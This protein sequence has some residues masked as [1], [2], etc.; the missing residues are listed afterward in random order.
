MRG[1]LAGQAQAVTVAADGECLVAFLA[2]CRVSVAEN[3]LG[4]GLP[5]SACRLYS[6]TESA[7]P[8]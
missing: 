5:T 1:A 2:P 6:P 8:A 7:A 3:G 4:F